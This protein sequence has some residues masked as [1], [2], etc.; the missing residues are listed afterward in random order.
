MDETTVA[1]YNLAA[2]SYSEKFAGIGA[3]T[4]DI[5]KAFE[6]CGKENPKVLELGCGDGRDAGEICRLTNN[7]KGIDISD[8]LIAIA[9]KKLPELDFEVANMEAFDFTEPV[10]IIFAFASLLHVDKDHF[11]VILDKAHEALSDGGVFYISVKYG[12]YK[13]AQVVTDQHGDRTF[14]FYEE[15]DIRELAT[16]YAIVETRKVS[17][18]ST[19]WLDVML[20]KR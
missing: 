10:D 1:T 14:Y 17:I 5:K 16:K 19:P 3:R 18:G 9:K 8:A 13:G 15:S 4:G 7:Y 6:T 12:P 11:K 20:Q 2:D